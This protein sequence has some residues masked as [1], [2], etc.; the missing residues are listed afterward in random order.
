[1][2]VVSMASVLFWR[3]QLLF[4]SEY[5]EIPTSHQQVKIKN[6][7]LLKQK[8]LQEKLIQTEE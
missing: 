1:M 4:A 7:N 3:S 8:Q 5:Q 6:S 2:G